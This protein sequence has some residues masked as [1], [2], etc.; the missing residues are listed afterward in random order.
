MATTL[1]RRP[2]PARPCDR[3]D[4]GADHRSGGHRRPTRCAERIGEPA[5][6]EEFAAFTADPLAIWIE[7][8]FGFEPGSPA[9]SPRRRRR[10][11]TL[12]EAARSS[13]SRPAREQAEC[14][15]AIKDAL[16]AG[17]R[18]VNPATGRP[19]FAFRLHQFLS[20]GDNVYV[21]LEPPASR[22]VTSTY[23]VAAPGDGQRPGSAGSGS[24]CRRRS[25]ASA[26][27]TTWR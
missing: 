27:R 4:A 20:K 22:H 10:P 1:V 8:V 21:T 12:P 23:Q 7:E 14:A 25:A 19:V 17:S 16:Q 11:P 15:T 3:G 5:P 13:P 6:P 18:I 9:G 2:G 24:W 26:A